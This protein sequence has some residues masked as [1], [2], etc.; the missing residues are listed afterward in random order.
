M[1]RAPAPTDPP[2]PPARR[3]RAR[4]RAVAVLAMLSAVALTL[5][6]CTLLPAQKAAPSANPSATAGTPENLKAYY[7]QQVQWTGCEKSFECAKVTVPVDYARPASDTIALQLIRKGASGDRVGSLVMNP[8]GPGG[9]GYTMV[10]DSL[11]AVTSKTLRERFDVVSFDPRGVDRSAGI[12]CLTDEQRDAY[13]QDDSDPAT[14]AGLARATELQRQVAAACRQ[15]SGPVLGH[16]DTVSAARDLDV[17]RAVLGE[18]RLTYLG[19]SYGTQLG[20]TFA[21][22]FPDRAGRLVLDGAV[23]PSLSN[24]ELTLGQARAFEQALR[25]W[26]EACTRA[27]S[28][29]FSSADE[30]V[31]LVRTL[32]TDAERSPQTVADGRK[33]TVGMLAS[34]LILPLYN[35]QSWEALNVA[36]ANA[37]SGDPG[38][39]IRF[40]DIG[41]DREQDGRYT[42]NSTFAFQAVNCLDYPME[43]DPAAMRHDAAA[44]QQ[45]SPTL[46]RY[47]GYG[48]LT[49][50][51]WPHRP[52]SAPHPLDAAGAEPIVVIG[53]TGDPA[54]PVAWARS[55]AD[56]LQSGRLITF[57]GEGHTAYGQGDTCVV[58]AVDGYLVDGTVPQDGLRC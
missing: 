22:L 58:D 53:T 29:A 34:G 45:A 3:P 10:R 51:S 56:Q 26:A 9:S 37:A 35:E 39:L 15:K 31:A 57:E 50:A 1:R 33:A 8:G 52:V 38:D 4:S 48:G 23:D 14:A 46:G 47:F 49:C 43:T 42:A 16:M 27:S 19:Y 25:S 5:S 36:V 44:L 30:G 2:T 18:T 6:G 7:T 11:E 41:A 55:L 12:T 20:A 32:L 40:S 13:R 17:I 24:E 28:C 54:T 21:D